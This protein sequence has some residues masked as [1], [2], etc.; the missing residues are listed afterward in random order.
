VEGDSRS[1]G[2]DPEGWLAGASGVPSSRYD[3]RLSI[4]T[5]PG[6]V[7]SSAPYGVLN[8]PDPTG[9]EWDSDGTVGLCYGPGRPLTGPYVVVRTQPARSDA[10]RLLECDLLFER[11]NEEPSADDAAS[12]RELVRLMAF[13]VRGRSSWTL[14]QDSQPI[15]VSVEGSDTEALVIADGDWWAL[16]FEH[17]ASVGTIV[18]RR[19]R[20]EPRV[21]VHRVVDLGPFEDGLRRAMED[22]PRHGPGP[23]ER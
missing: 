1:A 22:E 4:P 23:T 12:Q 3:R 21:R 7:R 18:A 20:P 16:R 13:E 15:T 5:V 10:I 9:V 2:R 14:R 6:F 17:G 19:W 11:Q 8:G